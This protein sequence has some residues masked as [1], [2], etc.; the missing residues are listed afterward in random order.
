MK[1]HYIILVFLLAITKISAQTVDH[2]RPNVLLIITDDQGYGD[3]GFT[4]NHWVR[5]PHLDQL[6]K[7]SINFSQFY[8]SPVCAPTRSSL[9]TGRYSLRTGVRDTYNGGAILAGEETTL[10]EVLQSKGYRTGIFGKWHL[11]DTYPSR[12]IDQGFEESLVH[13]AGGMGQVGD[14]TTYFNGDSSYYDPVLWHNGQREAYEGHCTDIFAEG[15]LN[16]IQEESD[17]PFFCYLSFNAPH[18]PLQVPQTYYNRYAG[19]DPSEG[20]AE[21]E[22]HIN[23]MTER[24]KEDARKVYAM[25]EQIDEHVG[26]I[27]AAVERM[28]AERETIVIFMTDN[29]PQQRRYTAGRR[30]LKGSVY[31]GGINVPLL[32][33]MPGQEE[34]LTIDDPVAHF[35]LFP[36]VLE[37]IGRDTPDSL[38][39]DGRSLM[40]LIRGDLGGKEVLQQRSI[41]SYWTRKFP[42]RYRN[43]SVRKGD[44]KLVA[45]ADYDA[46]LEDFELYNVKNDPSEKGNVIKEEGEM[47]QLLRGELETFLDELLD[48]EHLQNP[49][50]IE[51]GT[52]WENPVILNRND[53]G[54]E[55]GIW[56][57]EEIH[58]EW[59]VSFEEGC[60]EVLVDFIAPVETGGRMV[61]ETADGVFTKQVKEVKGGNVVE[62]K[63][64][65]MGEWMGA[66]RVTYWVGGRQVMP[67]SMEWKRD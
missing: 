61:I 22:E 21:G 58:G 40:P 20:F 30:G 36:T 14:V 17:Q 46:K 27:L 51:V 50:Y 53:A 62:L 44:W 47:G 54:G 49:P 45:F 28:R 41:F 52:E 42:E 13:L 38:E 26:S 43:M 67:F 31:E 11:G 24:D 48:S 6:A 37:M 9:M 33:R 4:G 57:Q 32:V 16:F 15:A 3:F 66:L 25:V 23:Q 7:E 63:D 12:P 60:Y 64:L 65:C 39:L 5:T 56:A 18:T 8:V 59:R 1:I 2:Q 10:A 55:R 29:G 19:I 35:D 34:Q